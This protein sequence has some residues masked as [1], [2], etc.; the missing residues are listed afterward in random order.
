MDR[1]ITKPAIIA[2]GGFLGIAFMLGIV[3]WLLH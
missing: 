1:D 2:I 3:L